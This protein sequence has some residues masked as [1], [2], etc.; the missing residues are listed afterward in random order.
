M[1]GV[2]LA[3]LLVASGKASADT[4]QLR[5]GDTAHAFAL[6]DAARVTVAR[7]GPV[8]V[9]MDEAGEAWLTK[10]TSA[11]VGEVL[12]VGFAG[13]PVTDPIIRS[14]IYGGCLYFQFPVPKRLREALLG[15]IGERMD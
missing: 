1:R 5:L 7:D 3:L 12:T 4:F 15:W 14:P 8:E 6:A 10:A 2:I 9:C 11:N 13:E